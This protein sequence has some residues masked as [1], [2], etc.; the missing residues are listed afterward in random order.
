M[1]AVWSRILGATWVLVAVAYGFVSVASRRTGKPLWWVDNN[2]V[3]GGTTPVLGAAILYLAMLAAFVVALQ[4]VDWAPF[5]SAAVSLGLGASAIVDLSSA[6]G[7]AVVSLAV[8]GAALLASTAALAGR[9]A[10]H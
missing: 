10:R 1:S 8:A 7:A 4:R 2:G 5:A 3:I 6:P 9:T